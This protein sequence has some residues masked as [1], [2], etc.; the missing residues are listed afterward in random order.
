MAQTGRLL[1]Q[2]YIEHSRD[3]KIDNSKSNFA[4]YLVENNYLVGSVKN[5]LNVLH[6][7][8]KVGQM[9][10]LRKISYMY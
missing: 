1:C 4:K 9:N 8:K 10:A 5:I 3:F 2:R 6:V 7:R